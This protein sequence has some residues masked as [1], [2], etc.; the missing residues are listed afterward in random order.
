[1]GFYTEGNTDIPLS[2]LATREE[3][4][5]GELITNV[6][7]G[8]FDKLPR[9]WGFEPYDPTYPSGEFAE[10]FRAILKAF[11]AG[12]GVSYASLSGDLS[13]TSYASSRVG[14]I[15]D[16]DHYR[17][18]QRWFI[19]AF[20]APLYAIWLDTALLAGAITTSAGRPLP[21]AK[22]A[23]FAEAHWQTRG[24]DWVDPVKD[25]DAEVMAIYAGL[26]TRTEALAERGRD[27][28]ETMQQ[29]AEEEELAASL[30]LMF[31]R[32]KTEAA[33]QTVPVEDE[34]N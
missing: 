10:F 6:L 11:A 34:R 30:G 20:Y 28:R 25:I 9:G 12:V 16:R 23:K 1:M 32:G 27:L 24:Y 29:L 13:D 31:S 33:R 3:T 21:W 17:W 19:G 26:K 14:I 22:R 15:D 4:E 5:T 8:V 2:E 18:L 7:P